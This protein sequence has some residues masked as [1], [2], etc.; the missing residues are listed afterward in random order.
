LEDITKLE[1][2]LELNKDELHVCQGQIEINQLNNRKIRN[3]INDL[4]ENLEEN[5]LKVQ[6]VHNAN[7]LEVLQV[8]QE[9]NDCLEQIREVGVRKEEE[10]NRIK[11]QDKTIEQL[12]YEISEAEYY[13]KIKSG[14]DWLVIQ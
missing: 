9:I 4:Q 5:Q 6:N 7:K 11:Q 13:V 3:L 14:Q 10:E 12:N 8:Q 2:E 1:K